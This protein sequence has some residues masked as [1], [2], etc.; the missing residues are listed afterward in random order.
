MARP[1]PTRCLFWSSLGPGWRLGSPWTLAGPGCVWTNA[2]VTV[3]PSTSRPGPGCLPWPLASPMHCLPSHPSL[4]PTSAQPHAAGNKLAGKGA[5]PSWHAFFVEMGSHG[6]WPAAW[7]RVFSNLLGATVTVGEDP[8]GQLALP[9]I[10][11]VLPL[12]GGLS[13]PRAPVCPASLP[14]PLSRTTGSH[15]HLD[16]PES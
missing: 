12:P 7:S 10:S 6:R 4:S 15:R 8:T 11:C 1:L 16:Q 13:V 14:W 2:A 3:L 9:C 5:V